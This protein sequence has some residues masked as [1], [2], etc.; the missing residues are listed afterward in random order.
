M[1]NQKQKLLFII[2]D[3]AY[4]LLLKRGLKPTFQSSNILHLLA[5]WILTFGFRI[6]TFDGEFNIFEGIFEDHIQIFE[7]IRRANRVQ[8]LG[9]FSALN[10]GLGFLIFAVLGA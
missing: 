8:L 5:F 7:D 2:S 9:K 1:S 4:K 6:L 3:S 10:L